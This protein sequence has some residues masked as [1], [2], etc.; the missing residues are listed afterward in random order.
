MPSNETSGRAILTRQRE[1]DVS[2]FHF[3]DNLARAIRHT[4][5]VLIDLIPHVYTGARVIRV[6][7]PEGTVSKVPLNAPVMDRGDQPGLA[8]PGQTQN[9][10]LAGAPGGQ[11][12]APAPQVY[13][14]T[15]GKYDLAV[16][17]GPSF[18]TRRE[19]A[20]AQMTE[21]IRAFPAAAPV[22]GDL[23]A[24]NLDWP[25]ADEIAKR[26]QALN[27]AAQ[28][29]NPN[30]EMAR[31]GQMIQ[32]LTAHLKALQAD[33]SLELQKLAIDARKADNAAYDSET[34]RLGVL[35]KNQPVDT[36]A[37]V[38]ETIR[39][40]M[41]GPDIAPGPVPPLG[42]LPGAPMPPIGP[43]PL[44]PNGPPCRRCPGPSAPC[45]PNRTA[46]GLSKRGAG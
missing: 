36:E 6:L 22:L 25:G 41:D 24:K 43:V 8:E 42:G 10:A 23:L 31:M 14:F 29:G 18:T 32:Q 30:P 2:T 46:A 37:I 40:I 9:P 16:E 27:P 34:K 11:P 44:G 15:M 13:N 45:R 7:G 19:E 38:Q 1:G 4:G 5:R 28:Q 20:A 26:L 39:R 35:A 21:L 3:L 33:K 12:E 17:T